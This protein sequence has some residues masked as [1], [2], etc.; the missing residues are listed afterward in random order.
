[1]PTYS[2]IRQDTGAE[3]YCYT[4]DHPL[5]LDLFPPSLFDHVPQVEPEVVPPPVYGGR[6]VLDRL[7]F[8]RLFTAQERITLVE[9]AK[10]IPVLADYMYLL[11]RTSTV[12]L[13]HDDTLNG[14]NLLEQVGL[15][16]PGRAAEVLHG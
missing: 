12:H 5:D 14:V 10:S 3:V 9:A 1:V 6:R 8:L 11:D 16:A 15:I 2:V 13:D 4:Y 7:E